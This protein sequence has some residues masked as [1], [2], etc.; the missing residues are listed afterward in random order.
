MK[1]SPELLTDI[2]GVLGQMSAKMDAANAKSSA[3]KKETKVTFGAAGVIGSLLGK[4]G[5]AAKMA[6][7]VEKLKTAIKGFNLVRLNDMI[8]SMEKYVKLSK[9]TGHAAK[10]SGWAAAGKEIGIALMFIAGGILS[11]GLVMGAS[12]LL[13]GVA[14]PLLV[15]LAI[16][17]VI[18]ILGSA[19]K[20]LAEMTAEGDIA[21]NN[22]K[23]KIGKNK[24]KGTS[25]DAISNAKDLGLALMFIAGG[26]LA[27]AITIAL[28]PK[29][30]GLGSGG[31]KGALFGVL[32]V[33]GIIG[34]IT[35]VIAVLG[36]V[37]RFIQPGINVAKGIGI[38]L[39]FL[40][41]GVFVV[42]LTSKVLL[43][44]FRGQKTDDKGNKT[45]GGPGAAILNAAAGLGIF[46][47]FVAGLSTLLWV[48]G[49]PV[50]SGPIA[51]GALA[52]IGMSLSLITTTIAIKKVTDTMKG[53]NIK[54]LRQN[55]TDMV[56]AVMGGVIDGVMGSGLHKNAEGNTSSTGELSIREVMQ[57]RRITRVIRMLGTISK[58]ISQFAMGL[59][60]FAKLGEIAS[61]DYE[62]NEKGEMKPIIGGKGKIH[63]VEI[64]KAIADT[65]GIF[66]KSLVENTQGL[67]RRQARSLKI[68][69]KSLVGDKGIISGVVQFA[70]ALKTFSE[71]G[72]AGQIYV[73]EYDVNGQII[74]TK[75]GKEKKVGVPIIT[76]TENIVTTF[77]KFVEAMA[78]K[79]PLF[80]LGG[81]LGKKMSRFSEA[82]M[83]TEKGFL[84]RA[85]PGILSAITSFNDVL[86]T[87][88][89]Y[90]AG[91][92]I[93]KK[94]KD[95]NILPNQF[96]LVDT[97][98]NNMVDGI[99][100]FVSSLNKALTG[101][102]LE[103]S[104]KAV[105]KQ[106]S[107]FTDIITQFDKLAESQEGMDKLST[108]MGLLAN[109]I[110][111][112][113]TNMGALN[114]DKLNAL[115]TITAQ[116]AVTTKGIT[117]A[118]QS[119]TSA[120]SSTSTGGQADW[121]KVADRMGQIIAQKLTG[122]RGGEFEFH[123]FDGNSGG[124]LE[125]KEK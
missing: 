9:E 34:V 32:A 40:S 19:M 118:P 37:Q 70:T 90:G 59:R 108:S 26:V 33:V 15:P 125:I 55:I 47:I 2:L 74:M 120:A 53:M 35:G 7:D 100:T 69:G 113:V 48:M 122:G 39:L 92:K 106:I 84:R 21:I 79:A 101:K 10:I 96:V 8:E 88:S 36:L 91:G 68:L 110:G 42:A 123:F 62:Y 97:V 66:I 51:L 25:K 13:F 52:L 44:M 115:A 73:P 76:I 60:A 109:N 61:L 3:P 41:A 85:K 95:G 114:T 75:E 4:K 67:T 119:S 80:E 78:A 1:T 18:W 86:L 57:F 93:P 54:I 23:P 24:G 102:D 77:G 94:D 124:K 43:E 50:V 5:I 11:F 20:M 63:V 104:S 89:E 117:I 28:V 14:G 65:F 81:V 98:A 87:Y 116:H 121:D 16:F 111:L 12:A 99:T 83:G 27:F 64:A 38:A 71:F 45:K 30:L 56:S 49:L 29:I 105:E 46:G 103:T 6:E 112:L 82:L 22:G 58:S 31:A 72:A 107:S 17:G